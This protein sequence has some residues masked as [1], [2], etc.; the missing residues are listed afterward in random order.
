M[1]IKFFLDNVY[2]RISDLK[3]NVQMFGVD[4]VYHHA[5]L[6]AYI[7]KYKQA[8]SVKESGPIRVTKKKTFEH[9]ITFIRDVIESV[10]AISLNDICDMIN[11]KKQFL[12]LT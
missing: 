4:L 12:L 7:Q 6:S 5:C 11:H 9:Y 3:N 10:S 2:A 1:E 8:K